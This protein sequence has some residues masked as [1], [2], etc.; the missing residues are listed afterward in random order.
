MTTEMKMQYWNEAIQRHL[1]QYYRKMKSFTSE[2]LG[3]AQQV[4]AGNTNTSQILQREKTLIEP[5]VKVTMNAHE[6]V[7]RR[8]NYLR[9]TT[10][11]R[12]SRFSK[13]NSAKVASQPETH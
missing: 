7:A 10:T 11:Q 12:P 8:K 3:D 9:T 13:Q 4:L 2:F 6:M 1:K 5:I